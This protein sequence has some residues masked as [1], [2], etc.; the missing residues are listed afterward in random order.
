VGTHE[1]G[2]SAH[3][4]SI[5]ALDLRFTHADPGVEEQDPSGWMTAWTMPMPGDP[6]SALPSGCLKP[7]T[8]SG[9]MWMFGFVVTAPMVVGR[10]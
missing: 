1:V 7:A 10:S 6:A 5:R 4:R 3:E 9:E 8:R 2:K